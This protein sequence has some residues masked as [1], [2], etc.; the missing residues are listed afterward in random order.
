[1]ITAPLA[2]P[3]LRAC[4]GLELLEQLSAL[5]TEIAGKLHAECDRREMTYSPIEIHQ[6]DM[7]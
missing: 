5:A 7:L 2:Y 1:M 3:E 6:G 4:K